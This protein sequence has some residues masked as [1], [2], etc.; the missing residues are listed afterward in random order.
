VTTKIASTSVDFND[1]EYRSDNVID[2]QIYRWAK[3]FKSLTPQE[4]RVALFRNRVRGYPSASAAFN[5]PLLPCPA[6]AAVNGLD[7]I[8]SVTVIENHKGL[9]AKVFAWNGEGLEKKSAAQIYDGAFQVHQAYGL[10]GLF[11]IIKGLSN[12]QALT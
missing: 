11:D 6:G 7:A 5:R 10:A 9:A 4:Q 12:K 2:L 3:W 8:A 1:D